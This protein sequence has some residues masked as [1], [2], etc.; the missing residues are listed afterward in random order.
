MQN[1]GV[2]SCRGMTGAIRGLGDQGLIFDSA[3]NGKIKP[4]RGY[5]TRKQAQE[6]LNYYEI[7]LSL[8]ENKF[9]YFVDKLG[10]FEEL[11]S[12]FS[13]LIIG[14][15][16]ADELHRR[17]CRVSKHAGTGGHSE[18]Y[19]WTIYGT[20]EF[21]KYVDNPYKITTIR[22]KVR[23][24]GFVKNDYPRYDQVCQ[25][26]REQFGLSLCPAGVGLYLRLK[27]LDQPANHRYEIVMNPVRDMYGSCVL[28]LGNRPD[29]G[30]LSIGGSSRDNNNRPELDC[31][32][33]FLVS[34]KPVRER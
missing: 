5:E 24:L 32:L 2:I 6:I 12:R 29:D 17:L 9:H 18:Y 1:G 27:D 21:K 10:S 22:L 13:S 4:A 3:I 8:G 11:K 28:Y 33:V 25:K 20:A 19:I 30:G 34:Q 23:D 14:G 16:T 15:E 26:A 7:L 31:E